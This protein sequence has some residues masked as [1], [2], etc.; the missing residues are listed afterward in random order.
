MRWFDTWRRDL[1]RSGALRIALVY[2]AAG[3]L[4]ITF[5]DEMLV[6]FV[7]DRAL[8][9][10]LSIGKGCAY[11]LVSGALLYAAIK[12]Q[13]RRS[14]LAWQRLLRSS[15]ERRLQLLNARN[16]CQRALFESHSRLQQ[17][18]RIAGF[19]WWSVE[20]DSGDL[21]LSEWLLQLF[22]A[23][24]GAQAWTLQMLFERVHPDDRAALQNAVDE[25]W[26]GRTLHLELRLLGAEA[27]TRFVV[28]RGEL[29]QLGA[30]SGMRLIGT[31]LDIDE[32][33]R[34]EKALEDGERQYRQ[35]IEHLPEA[36]LIYR[37]GQL[38]FANPAAAR[39]FGAARA[40]ELLG[41]EIDAFVAAPS[42]DAAHT[43]L[44]WLRAGVDRNDNRFE[45]R[46]LRKI[47]GEVFA[48][49]VASRSL[50]SNG[51]H[52]IQSIVRDISEQKKNQEDLR[53][54]NER[55]LHLSTHMIEAAESERLHLSREL[56]DDLG[57][58]L[59]FVKMT[60]GWLRKRL[61]HDEVSERVAQLYQAAAEALDKV[62]DL[63]Q[64][65]RPAQLDALGMKSAME[66]HLQKF[67]DGGA[68]GYAVRVDE[69]QP[70]PD[71]DIE[72]ALF[73]IFQEALTNI[74]RHSGAHF[75]EVELA[76]LHRAIELRVVDD[77]CG[78]DVAE[79][80]ASSTHLGLHTMSERARQLQGE[81]RWLSV[82]GVGTEMIATI[83][84]SGL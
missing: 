5:S 46:L 34:H 64:A 31:I 83:P 73:R 20:H 28:L 55:L 33:R 57:Q 48:A 9:V 67:C 17:L 30:G 54:A 12:R 69:L 49:E 24:A 19:G 81:V 37:E 82:P 21:A 70:R 39:L 47:S 59:T 41:M 56:H 11:V 22:G 13:Q 29:M 45:E 75:I 72:T 3:L 51:E 36:V 58:S 65:L 71:P 61:Q 84:E 35:L 27:E 25:V 40:D 2:V 42:R 66:E 1:H 15:R 18:Q 16:I 62:R 4:W 79:A 60:A 6:R 53:R 74:F 50:M 80:L 43:R 32:R 78:F 7:R 26:R 14:R 77:G 10:A 68:I 52:C 76:R 63:S 23:D 38:I 44:E 8:A